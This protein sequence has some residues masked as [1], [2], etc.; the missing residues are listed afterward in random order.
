MPPVSSVS[1]RASIVI[2]L[3][4]SGG[5]R[6][7]S[8]TTPPFWNAPFA[9]VW[10]SRVLS[11]LALHMQNVAVGW[12]LYSLTG[13]ALDLGLVGLA[14]FLPTVVLTLVVGQVADRY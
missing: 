8:A 13:S 5:N 9:L 1:R 4:S 14:Q 3:F 12:Q 7:Y 6:R 11:T 2:A 10:C